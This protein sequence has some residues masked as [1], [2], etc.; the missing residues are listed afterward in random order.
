MAHRV[1]LGRTGLQVSPVCYGTWQLSPAF[2]G[3]AP[4]DEFIRSMRRSFELGVNFY[5]TADAYGNGLAE[6]V[7]GKALEPLPR[8]QVVVATKVY[9]HFFPDMRRYG[10]LSREYIIAECE[11]SLRRLKMSYIDLYQCHAWDPLT[12]IEET[13]DALDTLVRQ[14]KIRAYGT[15][16]WTVE[17][18]RHGNQQG[19]FGSCQP[20]YSL[21]KRSIENDVLPYC[22][23]TD[24]GVL[25]YSSL[26]R[27][28]LSGKY[29][30]TE[31]FTDL[32]KN[33]PDFQGERFKLLCE[34][35]AD[36][37]KIAKGYGLTTIQAV[38]SYNLMHPGIT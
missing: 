31:T 32:R 4:E 14:G 19:R 25:V 33:D 9:W 28:L 5:D 22:Q 17:Q 13:I 7:T 34:R 24:T 26:Q 2:W 30:G 16:N 18:M 8:D 10:D 3:V 15:S 35:V 36:V 27:G 20:P 38:L 6:E 11:A 21:L 12:P 29:T 37:G 1:R 23:A